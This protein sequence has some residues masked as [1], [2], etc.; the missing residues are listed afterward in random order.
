SFSL[1]IEGGFDAAG[2]NDSPV[3]CQSRAPADPQIGESTFPSKDT[4]CPLS[5]DR[6]I[7]T[8]GSEL[9]AEQRSATGQLASWRIHLPLKGH[10]V[11]VVL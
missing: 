5:F 3:G 8:R 6:R 2:V 9:R 7:R 11:S 1:A 10:R 4:A